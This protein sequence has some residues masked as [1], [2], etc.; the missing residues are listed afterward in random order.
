MRP[1]PDPK[2]HLYL[3]HNSRESTPGRSCREFPPGLQ[4]APDPAG[5][6]AGKAPEALV[7]PAAAG[8]PTGSGAGKAAA[9]GKALLPRFPHG[10]TAQDQAGHEYRPQPRHKAALWRTTTTV[11][12]K[13]V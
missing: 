13:T 9:A 12:T 6:V 5:F 8:A 4:V 11:A 3:N 7:G 10:R 2:L 1:R